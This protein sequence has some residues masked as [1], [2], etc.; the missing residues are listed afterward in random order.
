M[1]P[2]LGQARLRARSGSVC[3]C[4]CWA[5]SQNL[6]A[7][8]RKQQLFKVQRAGAASSRLFPAVLCPPTPHS[9]CTSKPPGLGL[10]V[11]R[12]WAEGLGRVDPWVSSVP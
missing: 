11:G 6:A 2:R 8:V 3:Q 10:P 9:P 12:A 1:S 4:R 7:P 5:G